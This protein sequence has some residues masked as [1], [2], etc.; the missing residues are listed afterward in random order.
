MSVPPDFLISGEDIE[1]M[2]KRIRKFKLSQLKDLARTMLLRIAGKKADLIERI[3]EHIENGVRYDD[4]I[5]LL[6]IGVIIKKILLHESIPSYTSLYNAIRFGGPNANLLAQLQQDTRNISARPDSESLSNMAPV[7]Q[8]PRTKSSDASIACIDNAIYFKPSPFYTLKQLILGSPQRVFPS[9]GRMMCRLNF[10][11]SDEDNRIF[12][13]KPGKMQ[14]FL[15]CGA[16]K[17]D[18]PVTHSADI[19]WP[20]PQE[21]YVNGAQ[22]RENVKGIKGKPGTARPANITKFISRTP[23]LNKI[24]MVYAGTKQYYLLYCF[25]AETRSSQ[26]VA[27]EIFRGQH[28]HLLSTIDKIKEEYT[29][30]DDDLE[31]ATSSLS[32]K[33]PLTYSRMKFPAKSIYCQHIQCFDC[34]SFL[35]LQEQI[36]TWTCP[37]CSRGVELE[38]LA[39]SDYYLEILLKVND[40]VESVTL[41]PDGSW[42]ANVESSMDDE[43]SSPSPKPKSATE[44]VIEIVSIDSESED[45]TPHPPPRPLV[46]TIDI[47]LP[48]LDS[49]TVSH[50]QTREQFTAE[51]NR[52]TT[53]LTPTALNP[54]TDKSQVQ[55][56]SNREAAQ[57]NVQFQNE[58]ASKPLDVQRENSDPRNQTSLQNQTPSLQ[59]QDSS[60]NPNS[61]HLQNTQLLIQ[62]AQPTQ[63]EASQAQNQ[64]TQRQQSTQ[65]QNQSTQVQTRSPRLQN[66]N[67]RV[68]TQSPQLPVYNRRVQGSQLPDQNA[69]QGQSQSPRLQNQDFHVR[70]QNSQLPVL[71]PQLQTQRPELQ[72]QNA[73][74]R[75]QNPHL[76]V[77]NQVVQTRSPQL[78]NQ[79]T[80][81]GQSQSPQLPVQTSP[82]LQNQN[83]QVRN[84]N[85]HSPVLNPQVQTQ[86]PQFPAQNPRLQN[87]SPQLPVHDQRVQTQGPQLPV[88]NQQVQTQNSQ[89]PVQNATQVQTQNPQV[90]GQNPQLQNHIHLQTL[91]LQMQHQ[92]ASQ[93]QKQNAVAVQGRNDVQVQTQNPQL[94]NQNVRLQNLS[95]QLQTQS[96][97]MLHQNASQLQNQ[98]FTPVQ[99]RNVAQVQIQNS[100]LQSQ[101]VRLQNQGP[102]LQSQNMR[103]Q[104]QSPNLQ[105]QNTQLQ[106]R[107]VTHVQT[108]N[109]EFQSQNTTLQSPQL[110]NPHTQVQ[111]RNVTF[112][113]N[114]QF[115]SHNSPLQTQNPQVQG[116]N[117]TQN[118]SATQITQNTSQVQRIAPRL[119]GLSVQTQNTSHF[120]R[121][122]PQSPSQNTQLQ[123]QNSSQPQKNLTQSHNQA[124]LVQNPAS[125]LQNLD[126]ARLQS[127]LSLHNFV[128]GERTSN[129]VPVQKPLPAI[130]TFPLPYGNQQNASSTQ[131]TIRSMPE[132]LP[133]LNGQ[134]TQVSQQSPSLSK[135]PL[136]PL[137][138]NSA[139]GTLPGLSTFSFEPSTPHTQEHLDVRT[140]EQN[141]TSMFRIKRAMNTRQEQV[142]NRKD[143]QERHEQLRANFQNNLRQNIETNGTSR[144]TEVVATSDSVPETPQYQKPGLTYSRS[145]FDL[146]AASREDSRPLP[147]KTKTINGQSPIG[148]N[149]SPLNGQI[150]DFTLQTPQLNQPPVE[151]T[152]N[153]RLH[154]EERSP[155]PTK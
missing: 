29:H 37:I 26:E 100:Q 73:Q 47:P 93:L 36:P 144:P 5:K 25:I 41:N 19:E 67:Q 6:V 55:V 118:R 62:N 134:T 79:K 148:T 10:V 40:E 53:S 52:N 87:Q 70:N 106:N 7:P 43:S 54:I 46:E 138:A 83:T 27:D 35:Q 133:K 104:N 131:Q 86:S 75:N 38:E 141:L 126:I 80:T 49:A 127:S 33:C 65:L 112:V 109:P 116:Q 78:Q 17:L 94:Q 3:E 20:I 99:D 114:P 71:N 95:P 59:R 135:A 18:D 56:N 96:P 63:L 145:A 30:G 11:L 74:V 24:E 98:N 117:I 129:T 69:T 89:L 32:L 146:L 21:I 153:K 48:E 108:Q 58:G 121:N 8:M 77:H 154:S 101:N 142:S 2:K 57:N 123:T 61:S 31:V 111:N 64:G 81:H 72:N 90:L 119:P 12:R 102:Q 88:H 122:D 23:A 152:W 13:S 68:Q 132:L 107:N 85:H 42:L 50:P 82:Q 1:D 97:Q 44:E 51:W 110:Q 130:N 125:H 150:E 76:P 9:Q 15:L 124:P 22:L 155:S 4:K 45:E 105:N 39:I 16:F 91:S 60:R 120:Q 34:L 14:V 136:P 66:Q 143:L 28:I 151:R 113:P 115:Q 139:T 84:Q 137:R 128:N 92:H 103:L 149:L 147:K 140:V